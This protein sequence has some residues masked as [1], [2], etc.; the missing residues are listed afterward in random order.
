MSISCTVYFHKGREVVVGVMAMMVVVVVTMM[1]MT[2]DDDDNDDDDDDGDGD[3]EKHNND[4]G[5][6]FFY[7]CPSYFHSHEKAVH[8]GA[9]VLLVVVGFGVEISRETICSAL[10]YGD[11]SIGS[12]G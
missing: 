9:G 11:A 12:T 5:H 4:E 7:L 10:M 2:T 1:M 6:F 8:R 3:E